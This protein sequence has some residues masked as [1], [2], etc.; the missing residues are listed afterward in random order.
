MS[1]HNLCF[2]G[3]IKKIFSGYPLFDSYLELW[4]GW[5]NCWV[6]ISNPTFSHVTAQTIIWILPLSGVLMFTQD[7]KISHCYLGPAPLNILGAPLP[8][9]PLPG[10]PLI[11]PPL[12][13][14]MPLPPLGAPGGPPLGGPPPLPPLPPEGAPLWV[15]GRFGDFGRSL[16][17]SSEHPV[18]RL[19]SSG[20]KLW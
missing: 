9:I 6:N 11:N 10:P 1:T 13:P 7:S 16:S 15:P 4:A 14:L 17:I 3:E 2:H 18:V 19:V 20:N 5:I 8:L 12:S